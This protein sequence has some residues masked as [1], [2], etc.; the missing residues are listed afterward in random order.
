MRTRHLCDAMTVSKDLV[1]N[2]V[3]AAGGR[4]GISTGG[5]GS[6]GELTNR[7]GTK[8]NTD[9]EYKVKPYFHRTRVLPKR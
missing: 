3:L 2:L 6:N 9:W 1:A 5:G 7:D 8:K 4:G